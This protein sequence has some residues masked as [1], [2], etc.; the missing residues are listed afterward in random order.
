M[1]KIEILYGVEGAKE[2]KGIVVIIDVFR[3]ASTAAYLL[4]KGVKYIIP[5]S[6]K[7][8]A[9]E[10]KKENPDFVLM[11]EEG[12]YKIEGFELG[13]SPFDSNEY[14]LDGKVVIFRTTQGTQ[15]IVSATNAA[16][17]IFGSFPNAQAI[18]DY[19]NK[20]NPEIVSLVAMS[21]SGTKETGGKGGEDDEFAQFL[22]KKIQGEK[23][24]V[25]P[26]IQYLET[27][28]GSRRFLDPCVPEFPSE[29]FALCLA[30]DIFSFISLVIGK[31]GKKIIIKKEI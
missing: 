5:V 9:F 15:G 13:N 18:A 22:L 11:G 10:L 4:N 2:A 24:Q 29:D 16:E 6:T 7:E 28:E 31:D 20:K 17:V 25:D 3:A 19:I 1:P 26:I 23:P 27:H 30:T 21:G 8:E 12:G 14:D